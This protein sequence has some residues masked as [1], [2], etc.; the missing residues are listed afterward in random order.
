MS[1]ADDHRDWH[2]LARSEG[3][4]AW[5]CPFGCIDRNEWEEFPAL[6]ATVWYFVPGGTS[7]EPVGY[8][9]YS[10]AQ[11][12]TFAQV[13]AARSGRAARVEIAREEVPA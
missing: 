2:E 5:D 3:V 6:Y 10:R 9:V 12:R 13:A 4:N 7:K 1:M 11:A 8:P